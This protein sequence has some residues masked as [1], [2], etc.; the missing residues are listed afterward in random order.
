MPTVKP[1]IV[2][3]VCSD[4]TEKQQSLSSRNVVKKKA[5]Q[6]LVLKKKTLR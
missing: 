6:K 3:E 5:E 1:N 4:S 2:Q